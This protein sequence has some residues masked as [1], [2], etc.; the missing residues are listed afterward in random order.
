MLRFLTRPAKPRVLEREFGRANGEL[1]V[2]IETFQ[3]M[4]WKELFRS[5][6]R[7]LRRA[8][9]VEDRAIETLYFLNPAFLRAETVPE[10]LAPNAD[11]GNRSEAGDDCASS[12]L[13]HHSD[14]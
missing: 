3:S 6:V 5:P 12:R 2:T 7:D 10:I 13:I 14:R 1:R 8:M 11:R 9:R 4:R